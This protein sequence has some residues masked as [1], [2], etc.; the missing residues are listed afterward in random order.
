MSEVLSLTF[1]CVVSV[2]T[3]F[4]VFSNTEFKINANEIA[5]I[6]NY[7]TQNKGVV[8]VVYKT[9]SDSKITCA[10]GAIFEIKGK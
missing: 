3:A 1:F 8:H 7:C 9:N 2:L 10:D 4:L 6:S 5:K